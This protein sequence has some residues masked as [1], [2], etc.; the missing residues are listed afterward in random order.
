M[1]ERHF[2]ILLNCKSPFPSFRNFYFQKLH[3][4]FF[5]FYF[6]LTLFTLNLIFSIILNNWRKLLWSDNSCVNQPVDSIRQYQ[7]RPA[8]LLKTRL[9]H[10]CF[11]VNFAKFLRTPFLQNTSSGCFCS[12]YTVNKKMKMKH[13]PGIS[14]NQYRMD[15][16]LVNPFHT[17]G[18]FRYPLKAS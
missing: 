13:S 15:W 10:R 18:L 1:I 17:N 6:L 16:K 2:L 3:C 12:M 4:Y 14:M 11:P 8:T 9:W 7:A 5:I